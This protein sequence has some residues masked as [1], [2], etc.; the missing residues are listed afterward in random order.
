M[1]K[2]ASLRY[3]GAM[4]PPKFDGSKYTKSGSEK[5][6]EVPET[7]YEAFQRI[8][9][10]NL[11]K[12]GFG[13]ESAPPKGGSRRRSRSGRRMRSGRR[14]A[15]RSGR[16]TARRSGRR[17]AR[18]SGRRVARRTAR[19][20]GRRVGRRSV[21]RPGRGARR[22]V[23]RKTVDVSK[24]LSAP[25][26]EPMSSIKTSEPKEDLEGLADDFMD[27]FGNLSEDSLILEAKGAKQ[28]KPKKT[29]KKKG[30]RKGKPSE[31]NLF[32]KKML[33]I[34]KKENPDKLHKDL[35]KLVGQAWKKQK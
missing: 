10:P 8:N 29:K 2:P 23:R 33:P 26:W 19:R 17:T 15:R 30:S 14:T 18:R 24:G 6:E 13:W 21:R 4:G 25:D 20:V 11:S 12:T 3:L 5:V 31:Y 32:V 7:P 28:A 27:K 1:S 16:R 35:F 22:T 34:L 9:A